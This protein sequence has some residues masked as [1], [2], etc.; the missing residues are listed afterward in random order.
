MTIV[1]KN[2]KE[3]DAKK[4]LEKGFTLVEAKGEYEVLRLQKPGAT[5]T[6]Y[7]SGKMVIQTS[8]DND[9][10]YKRIALSYALVVV[11]SKEKKEIDINSS[12]T[13]S[14]V[15][16]SDETLKGDTFGGLVV[17]GAYFTSE[18]EKSLIELGVKDSKK[19]TDS[20]IKRIAEI[21]LAKYHN[22][23]VIE[24][25][26]VSEYNKKINSHYGIT[27][28]MN[29]LHKKV[30]GELRKRFEKKNGKKLIHFVDK[31]PGCTVGDAA[32][33]KGEEKSVNVAAA[34]IVARKIGLDQFEDLS[35][36]AGFRVP[37]GSTHVK[38]ALELLIKKDFNLK[39]F[40]KVS[41]KNVI[42]AKKDFLGS[43]SCGV[44]Y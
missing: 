9:S 2:V 1:C 31:Y 10:F 6:L 40:V 23:F 35:A 42:K 26:F 3:K 39:E 12:R 11:P 38:E 15:I 25:I 4:F 43:T 37:K 21:L 22:H 17:V 33:T 29:D 8:A 20:E 13:Y 28:L 18:E 30:G 16:G 32:E 19:L 27:A 24:N 5:I 7:T 34:S 41:F 36:K 14:G 44:N